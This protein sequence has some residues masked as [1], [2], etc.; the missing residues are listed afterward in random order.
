MASDQ[1]SAVRYP[2]VAFVLSFLSSGVGHIYSGQI[3]KGLFLYSARFILP[4]LCVI[5]AFS[6]RTNGVLVCMILLPALA[7][8]IIFLYSPIDAYATAKQV[9]ADY[10]LKEYNSSILYWL[11]VAMQLTY[12]LALT[13]GI[14]EYVYEAFYIPTRSMNPNLLAGDRVL[15]N[16]RPTHV[17]FPRRGD[18][19]AFR[20]PVS[21]AG[22]TWLSRVIGIAGDEIVIKGNEISVNG[23]KLERERVPKDGNV[24][25][26]SSAGR[27]YRILMADGTAKK[28]APD[29]TK[30]TVPKRSVFVMSDNRDLSRDS[31]H[32]G[33]I[34]DRDVV[35][36]VDY[37]FYPAESWSRFGVCQD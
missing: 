6:Q 18:L 23:M 32:I 2:W 11:L 36:H 8:V 29:E 25:Y 16:K 13:W 20:T 35:G 5:A 33:S 37:I 7:T 17:D 22:R 21:E 31:R 34:H 28:S 15:V 19:I 1:A 26:E 27:R 3:V 10:A 9:G 4:L 24:L 30:V 14:H 12:P